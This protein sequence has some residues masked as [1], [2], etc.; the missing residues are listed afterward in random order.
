M[1]HEDWLRDGG[2]SS[3]HML[4]ALLKEHYREFFYQKNYFA[5]STHADSEGD[6]LCAELIR[7]WHGKS[8][9]HYDDI[10]RLL[11]YIPIE[12]IKQVLSR[13]ANFIWNS[14]EVYTHIDNIDIASDEC[15]KI[16]K[17]VAERCRADGFSSFVDIYPESIQDHNVEFST[18]A[19][20]DAVFQRCLSQA[21]KKKGK[22]IVPHGNDL[23]VALILKNFI[24]QHDTL[25]LD[26]IVDFEK[27][28][29]GTCD[30]Q[31]AL[32]RLSQAM[33]RIE[34]KNFV[35]QH[36]ISFDVDVVDTTLESLL[37]GDY[38]P[39]RSIISFAMF[40]DCQQAWNLY[41]LESYCR[42][43]SKKFRFDVLRQNSKNVG[44]IVRNSCQLSYFDIMANALVDAGILLE[45]E[46]AL[47]FL[48]ENGYIAQTNYSKIND[49]ICIA[50][51][52]K[53]KENN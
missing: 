38:M 13:D 3:A 28:I 16:K 40:P 1:R 10:S 17:V 23:D 35:A 33:I 18:S 51:K 53:Y 41:T 47:A 5:L 37:Q 45:V 6:A 14:R 15:V 25:T 44:V 9:L 29:T 27:D 42:K 8:L 52:L 24:A 36:F 50:N 48:L 39:L 20:Q 49:L 26:E 22:I 21:Y 4:Q 46:P 30:R 43:Y 12:K 32:K 31:I 7:I 11:P 19:I 2:V 34:E